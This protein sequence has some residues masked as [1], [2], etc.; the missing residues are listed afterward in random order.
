[1][2]SNCV[3]WYQH[4]IYKLEPEA[5]TVVL[6]VSLKLAKEGTLMSTAELS[7]HICSFP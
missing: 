6:M 1:M 2:I 5:F 4:I 7:G 3:V